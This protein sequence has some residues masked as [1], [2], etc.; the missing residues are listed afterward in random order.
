M[1]TLK[2]FLATWFRS[3]AHC[4]TILAFF[5]FTM[6]SD[7]SKGLLVYKT[8]KK[9]FSM[10]LKY[11][12]MI[13]G[14]DAFDGKKTIR[15][16]I[17]SSKDISDKIKACGVMNCVDEYIEGVQ[18]DLDAAQRILY[19]I[20]LDRQ[21]TQYSGTAQLSAITLTTDTKDHLSGTLHIDDTLAGG[22]KINV[23]FDTSLKKAFTKHR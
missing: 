1:R 14:P 13:K 3:T 7:A 5:A 16:L 8:A 23:V 10:D 22:P 21:M 6:V 17:F 12:F 4:A 11:A 18:V 20:S 2:F 15:R 9:T 19:W